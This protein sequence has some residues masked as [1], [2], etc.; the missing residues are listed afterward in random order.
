MTLLL[1]YGKDKKALITGAGFG[2]LIV[3]INDKIIF[4]KFCPIKRMGKIVCCI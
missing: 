3:Y 2:E 1:I 4:I